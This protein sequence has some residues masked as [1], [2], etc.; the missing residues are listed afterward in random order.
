MLARARA[1]SDSAQAEET[2]AWFDAAAV[3][4]RETGDVAT[5]TAALLGLGAAQRFETE[6]GV[7]PAR[8]YEVFLRVQDDP[9]RRIAVAAAIARSWAYANVAGRGVPFA[10]LAVTA[11]QEAGVAD[12]LVDALDAALV[13][14]WGPDDF[15]IRRHLAR[16]IDDAAAHVADVDAHITAHLW[17]LTVGCERLDLPLIHRQIR[18]L[19]LLG[20]SSPRA[21]FFAASRRLMLDLLRGRTDTAPYLRERA[22]GAATEVF[23]ADAFAISHAMTAYP[24]VIAGDRATCAVEA[25]LYEEFALT[26]GARTIL[27]EAAFVWSAAGDTGRVAAVVGQ[28]GSDLHSVPRDHDWLLV[29]QCTLEAALFIDDRDVIATIAEL[30]TP[31][32]HR[33]VINAGAV[34]FHGVTDDTL[35]RA[36]ARIGN[37]DAARSFRRG[38]LATYRR[39]GAR[40]WYRRLADR[41]EPCFTTT[42]FVLR[43]VGDQLWEV[44]SSGSVSTVRAMRGLDHL[45]RLVRAPGTP[46]A[47]A[48]LV[49]AGTGMRVDQSGIET[50]DAQARSAYRRRIVELD[51]LD[52]RGRLTEALA[53]ER[54]ALHHQLDSATGLSGRMRITGTHTERARVAVRKAIVGALAHITEVQPELGKH[55]YAAVN[56]GASC[57]YTPGADP[58][59]WITDDA[60]R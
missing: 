5:W 49:A 10:Q 31:Y 23:I 37:D 58:P 8:L 3:R 48:D 12:W 53:T 57:D 32:A 44:G 36:H 45:R 33:A 7:L 26:E 56:T 40:W 13:V 46:I 20:E 18:A 52:A 11:A 17:T 47:A 15:E 30:L 59:R 54:A 38:A 6:A 22:A 4:A 51:A 55:L 16:E 29:M 34:A 1:C 24:A 19:E 60:V 43:P 50:L 27:A 9:P 35:T 21:Q 28:L 39:I 42:T 14:H 2:V 25:E 41:P